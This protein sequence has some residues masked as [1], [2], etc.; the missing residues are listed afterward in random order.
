[1]RNESLKRKTVF[2]VGLTLTDDVALYLKRIDRLAMQ[3]GAEVRL[4]HVITRW[5]SHLWGGQLP[6]E[7]LT[8]EIGQFV[9]LRKITE[10]RETLDSVLSKVGFQA[11]YKINITFGRAADV[12]RNDAEMH[13]SSLIVCGR[14]KDSS[15]IQG[16]STSAALSHQAPVPLL[17]LPAT[18][19]PQRKDLESWVMT[20]DLSHKPTLKQ[21]WD[22]AGRLGAKR[23]T[24]LHVFPL[25][26]NELEKFPQYYLEAAAM[27]LIQKVPP[28]TPDMVVEKAI[29]SLEEKMMRDF[30]P[31]EREAFHYHPEVIFGEPAEE[32]SRYVTSV[33]PDVVVFGPH[34][35]WHSKT[36][37]FGKVPVKAM[38]SLNTPICILPRTS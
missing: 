27:G 36:F 35:T 38:L 14:S 32:I 7:Y 31:D 4:V 13:H 17:V 29:R 16:L 22:I 18:W 10:A 11:P 20:D 34:E 1:M 25:S 23:L 19:E 21:A 2:T 6:S 28:L 33:K 15:G 26:K 5:E 9:E 8:A 37:S 3:S 24:H 12:L 30:T